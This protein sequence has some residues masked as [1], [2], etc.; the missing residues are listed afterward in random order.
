M[1]D[2][3][4]SFAW[5]LNILDKK[6]KTTVVGL[7]K[8]L[9][10]ENLDEDAYGLKKL[11]AL[12]SY[13]LTKMLMIRFSISQSSHSEAIRAFFT[14]SGS[15]VPLVSNVCMSVLQQSVPAPPELRPHL[16]VW[17]RVERL[18]VREEAP[19]LSRIHHDV[20]VSNSD[21]NYHRL[22]SFQHML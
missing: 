11:Y 2:G 17:L 6:K 18:E 19:R 21:L 9:E 13:Y 4:G 16:S 5:I 3:Q 20:T 1:S 22:A 10:F 14:F 12:W 8:G 15:S 7:M